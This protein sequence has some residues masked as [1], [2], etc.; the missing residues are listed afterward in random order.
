MGILLNINKTK[1]TEKTNVH[2]RLA[3]ND[4]NKDELM[5]DQHLSDQPRVEK[6][7]E[8]SEKVILTPTPSPR[9]PTNS[10]T[11]PS[12][13]HPQST[14]A[15]LQG[16]LQKPHHPHRHQTRFTAARAAATV[17]Q[18]E[19]QQMKEYA[20]VTLDHKNHDV[21]NRPN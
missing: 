20:P 12:T 2:P 3:S 4:L 18:L 10:T 1:G 11:K 16:K 6:P 5:S 19:A 15:C 21:V 9:V 7:S 17:Q 13:F 14:K 8:K